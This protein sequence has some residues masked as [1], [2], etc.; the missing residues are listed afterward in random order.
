MYTKIK[1]QWNLMVCH[2]ECRKWIK[3]P[4]IKLFPSIT[5]IWWAKIQKTNIN[6]SENMPS[7]QPTIRLLIFIDIYLLSG[8]ILSRCGHP[9]R[10]QKL[11]TKSI[12]IANEFN[13]FKSENT[14]CDAY[15]IQWRDL[16][17]CIGRWDTLHY[18]K[19]RMDKIRKKQK[20]LKIHLR[21]SEYSKWW[22]NQ[23]SHSMNVKNPNISEII[24][25]NYLKY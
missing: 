3:K 15:I 25:F 22:I 19:E 17:H 18:L 21:L 8:V 11:H 4:K 9:E 2:K 13:F 16:A 1:Y 23:S 7:K 24:L 20:H 12:K 6:L 5:L 14:F 10:L